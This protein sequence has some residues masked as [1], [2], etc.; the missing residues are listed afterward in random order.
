MF[1]LE[2]K[3]LFAYPNVINIYQKHKKNIKLFHFVLGVMRVKAHLFAFATS[4]V[5]NT[6]FQAL[7][8]KNVQTKASNISISIWCLLKSIARTF[9]DEKL[10]SSISQK[11][12]AIKYT[13][14]VFHFKELA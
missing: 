4:G 5:R 9:L 11:C 3:G 1:I 12:A 8:G 10:I 6:R 14:I 13:D 7:W 2:E